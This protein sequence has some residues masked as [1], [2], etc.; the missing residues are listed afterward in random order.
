MTEPKLFSPEH[1][2]LIGLI[3]I[4]VFL[5]LCGSMWYL[6]KKISQLIWQIAQMSLKVD[7][8]FS[9]FVNEGHE[10]TGGDKYAH[11]A[12]GSNK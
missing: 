9:W 12:K 7:I 11:L 1:V 2:Q 10:I 5:S 4:P 6:L 3:L 8:M